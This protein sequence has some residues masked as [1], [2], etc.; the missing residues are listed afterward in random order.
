MIYTPQQTA[1][2]FDAIRNIEAGNNGWS[3]IPAHAW[4]H[5]ALQATGYVVV[6][7]TDFHGL[8]A[9]AGYTRAAQAALRGQ[10]YAE[11]TYKPAA[12]HIGAP[13]YEAAIL[14]RQE[15]ATMDY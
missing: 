2:I 4:L 11:S 14:A 12:H 10:P 13:D 1:V 15:T 6:R 3:F 8:P 7:K 5:Q 9:Y